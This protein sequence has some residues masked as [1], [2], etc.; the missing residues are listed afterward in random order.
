MLKDTFSLVAQLRAEAAKN[1]GGKGYAWVARNLCGKAAVE[2]IAKDR[3]IAGLQA[4]VERLEGLVHVP[5]VW[6][7]AKCEFTLIQSNLNAKDGSIT[8]RDK[9]GDKCP[10]DGS[11][12]WRVSYRDWALENEKGWTEL[13]DR[14][15]S[16]LSAVKGQMP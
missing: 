2:I 5:G 10:N 1:D 6:R 13:L 9:P 11:P 12:L 16:E 8:A 15:D 3:T 7:C 4:E 14:K